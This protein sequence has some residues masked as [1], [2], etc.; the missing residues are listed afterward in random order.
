VGQLIGAT[1]AESALERADPVAF[2]R[3]GSDDPKVGRASEITRPS[4]T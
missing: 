1:G 3:L 4:A 2:K